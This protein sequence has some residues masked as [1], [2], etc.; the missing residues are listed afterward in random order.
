MK[1]TTALRRILDRP[2]LTMAVSA[3]DP[4]MARLV[5]REGFEVVSISG[6]AVAAT[7]L[8]MPDMGFLNLSDIVGVSRRIAAAVD[9]P[10][11]VDADT[12]YGN[13][14]QVTR[15]VREFERAGV[16]GIILEDQIEYKKCRMIE[17]GHPVVP[18]EEHAAKIR[19]ACRARRDPDFVIMAR[20]DAAADHSLREAI[21]RGRLY[22]EAGADM[23][24]I[25]ILG[26]PEEVEEIAAG[27]IPIPLKGNMDEGKRLWEIDFPTLERAGYRIASFPGVVRYA[28]LRAAAE[29]LRHLKREG[30]TAAIRDRLA[31]KDEWFEAVGL[32]KYMAIEREFLP[33]PE[34]AADGGREG[35]SDGKKR[36]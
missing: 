14:V 3:H 11:L 26:T 18:A 23:L 24:D 29:S 7:Y 16:A 30:S 2:G 36:A 13:A 1:P 31:S 12:G 19:A 27:E 33:S 4:L 5:Q 9:L 21:R 17:A 15:T 20:T 32:G 34:R 35:N 10:V 28:V 8:G 22:A 25:E 6:N